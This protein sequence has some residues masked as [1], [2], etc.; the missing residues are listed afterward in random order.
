LSLPNVLGIEVTDLPGRIPYLITPSQYE[1]QWQTRLSSLARPRIG[2]AWSVLARDVHAF[3]TVQ[4]SVPPAALASLVATPDVSFVSVQPAAA[5]DPSI[6]GNRAARI[7]DLHE[8][9]RD[10]GDTAAIITSLDLLITADTAV[11]HVAGALGVP[12]WMLDRHNTCWRW[13]LAS[14]TTS[15]YPTMMIFRQRRMGDWSDVVERVRVQ[16]AKWCTEQWRTRD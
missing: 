4:K 6:F 11:A 2:L 8:E 10:F 15:W 14:E 9:I 1:T 5:G 16:L 7:V 13:R 3:V 12:V